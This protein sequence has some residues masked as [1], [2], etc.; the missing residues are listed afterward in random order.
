MKLS[1]HFSLQS[2][3]T[4]KTLGGLV[5]VLVIGAVSSGV[6]EYIFKGTFEKFSSV[7]L[8]TSA[9]V[10]H[11]YQDFLYS[12][13]GDGRAD[14]L[15]PMIYSTFVV[16]LIGAIWILAAVMFLEMAKTRRLLE[17]VSEDEASDLE[18]LEDRAE[19]LKKEREELKIRL[20]K[21]HTKE[22]RVFASFIPYAIVFTVIIISFSLRDTYSRNACIFIERSIEILAPTI[23][24]EKVLQLKAKYRSVDDSRKFYDL[25]DELQ[26]TAREKNITL[27]KFT[28]IQAY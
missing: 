11:G 13:I 15:L 24:P 20:R 3:D 21:S 18:S 27:P 12:S 7:F 23:P 28:P 16:G 5:F 6:W 25:N 1:D 8:R 4:P 26:R 22:K 17:Q 10:F 9:T 19:K 14:Q 2:N